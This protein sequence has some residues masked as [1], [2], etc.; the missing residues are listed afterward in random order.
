MIRIA[1]GAFA[2][3]FAIPI[4]IAMLFDFRVLSMRKI[5]LTCGAILLDDGGE[6]ERLDASSK[7]TFHRVV[8]GRA[9]AI[10]R[11]H[12]AAI[13]RRNGD[14]RSNERKRDELGAQPL[15]TAQ[16]DCSATFCCR[17]SLIAWL[18]CSV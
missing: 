3:A 12:K 5:A 6:P 9:V 8:R 14:G 4:G 18:S 1:Y 10:E 11:A 16:R 17:E 7:A 13:E 2:L 15:V